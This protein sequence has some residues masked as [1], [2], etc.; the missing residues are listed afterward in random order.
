MLPC[1]ERGA[2]RKGRLRGAILVVALASVGFVHGR[3]DTSQSPAEAGLRLPNVETAKRFSFGFDPVLADYY[4]IRSLSRVGGSRGRVDGDMV[5]QVIELVTRLDPWVEHPYRFAAL[6]MVDGLP[7]VRAANDILK[8]GIAYHPTDW[9]NRFHLG[10]NEFYYLQDNAEAARVLEPAIAMEGAPNY[11]GA[12]VAR[13]QADGGSLDAAAVFLDS[14]IKGATNDF[15]RA[16]Y[17][18][19]FDEI[20]T[21]RRARYLDD[22]RIAF[23]D[24]FG[25]DIVKPA[26]L[27]TGT[28][29]VIRRIP[30]PHP[31]FDGFDW[32]IDEET[33]EIVSSFYGQRYRLHIHDADKGFRRQWRE[34]FGIGK[35][36]ELRGIVAASEEGDG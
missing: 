25:H 1:S 2:R 7:Q 12:F 14:L 32:V 23:W 17:Q 4:W 26:D 36:Q 20:E 27:W 34:E 6:W 31:H 21:E 30:R 16:E 9:R 24:R 10:Y 13:L 3:I 5:G 15:V 29:P 11:L 22:A 19:S 18:K 33:R 8:R 35:A 28:A